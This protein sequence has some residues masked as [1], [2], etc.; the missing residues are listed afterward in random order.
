MKFQSGCYSGQGTE[1][2][3]VWVEEKNVR[4]GSVSLEE[5]E[6][7]EEEEGCLVDQTALTCW[8]SSNDQVGCSGR[9]Y[10][11]LPSRPTLRGSGAPYPALQHSARPA[12]NTVS[13]YSMAR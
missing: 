1:S 5:E 13:I 6:E 10:L 4:E 2:D 11:V 9:A 8:I 12:P 7:E 3:T